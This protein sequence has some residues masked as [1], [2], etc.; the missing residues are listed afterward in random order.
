[1]Q[2]LFTYLKMSESDNEF[3]ARNYEPQSSSEDEEDHLP[4]NKKIVLGGSSST[5]P[6]SKK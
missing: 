4:T 5:N 2:P 6:R 3:T 1:M